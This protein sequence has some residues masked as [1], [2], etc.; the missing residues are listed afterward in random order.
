MLC[1][2]TFPLLSA[3]KEAGVPVV[4][5]LLSG[6]DLSPFLPDL[7]SAARIV[8]LHRAIYDYLV[9]TYPSMADQFHLGSKLVDRGLFYPPEAPP[10]ADGYRVV[11]MGRLSR[12]KGELALKVMDAV[13][14]SREAIP[15]ITMSVLGSGT[16][17]LKV[18]AHAKEINREAGREVVSVLGGVTRPEEVLRQ[19]DMAFAAGFSAAEALACH[20][21]VVGLGMGGLYGLV[22]P[23]GLEDA[24]AANFGDTL[25]RW[26]APTAEDM[27]AQLVAAYAARAESREWM[28]DVFR[29][30]LDPERVL[31]DY[32]RVL[33][34]A[35]QGKGC[36]T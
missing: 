31:D 25:A 34:Q 11:Y 24:L 26:K 36:A 28:E 10:P 27:A 13:W 32:E 8:V 35:A 18:R 9:A 4:V 16:R 20:C 21:Q 30:P 29:G 23:E 2:A 7:E 15:G 1:G 6:K 12:S 33:T 19:S 3:C 22:T 14:Q 17:L 5:T